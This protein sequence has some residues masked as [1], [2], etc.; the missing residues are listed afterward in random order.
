M[1]GTLSLSFFSDRQAERDRERKR[2]GHSYKHRKKR[3]FSMERRAGDGT[4]RVGS[5][6]GDIGKDF[7]LSSFRTEEKFFH[8]EIFLRAL[9]LDQSGTTPKRMDIAGLAALFHY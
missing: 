6:F 8:I 4:T 9:S 7:F 1:E 3:T 5:S 2:E